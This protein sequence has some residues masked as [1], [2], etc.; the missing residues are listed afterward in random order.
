[1]FITGASSQ[2]AAELPKFVHF[3][4]ASA[5]AATAAAGGSRADAKW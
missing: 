1:M 4:M 5:A 3:Q 2:A